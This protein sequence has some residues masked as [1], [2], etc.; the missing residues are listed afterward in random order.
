MPLADLSGFLLGSKVGGLVP[1]V[2]DLAFASPGAAAAEH[3]LPSID[4]GLLDAAVHIGGSPRKPAA[5]RTSFFVSTAMEFL[6]DML[7]GEEEPLP[8]KIVP[9]HFHVPIDDAWATSIYSSGTTGKG[10][11]NA[12]GP[13]RALAPGSGYWC[14][15]GH[16]GKDETITWK[17]YLHRRKPLVGMKISWAYAPGQVRVRTTP[18]G[19]QWDEVAK[20]H[21][22][23]NKEVSF[24]EDILFDRQRNVMSV[25]VDM[26]EPQDWGYYGINQA[27]ML[28]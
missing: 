10:P 16:H 15:S 25:R 9:T 14:S 12:Y 28:M 5:V 7:K 22:P 19:L 11:R 6:K 2:L 4:H 1:E 13:K 8:K 21:H 17:G 24:E 26:K 27:T 18:D 20:W 23:V 3:F